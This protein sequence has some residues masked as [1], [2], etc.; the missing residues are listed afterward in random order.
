M[1]SMLFFPPWLGLGLPLKRVN[2]INYEVD[3]V[4]AGTEPSLCYCGF[5]LGKEEEL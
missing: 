2:N 5:F 1:C 4:Y 3:A